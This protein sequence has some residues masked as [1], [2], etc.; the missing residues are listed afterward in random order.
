MDKL[1]RLQAGTVSRRQL[2][3][4]GLR[5]HDIER[6]GGALR[7]IDDAPL[8]LLVE[9]DGRLFHDSAGQRDLD[10][11]RDLDAVVDGRSTVRLGWGQVF[12]RPCYTAA[13]ISALLLRSGW[14]G[15]P[16]RCGPGCGL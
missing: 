2:E 10:L 4:A 12:E 6:V 13:R 9:L 5:P 8:R 1:L 15:R 3:D 14:T 11:D 16:Q 7:D